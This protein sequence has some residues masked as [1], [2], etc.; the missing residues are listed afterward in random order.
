MNKYYEKKSN[1][2]SALRPNVGK[3]WSDNEENLLL[4]ELNYVRNN[5]CNSLDILN[6]KI[7]NYLN[8]KIEK[9]KLKIIIVN[10]L[11]LILNSEYE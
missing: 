3:L 11:F 8:K 2:N 9:K 5:N 10:I 6:R 4:E 7:N 1:Y